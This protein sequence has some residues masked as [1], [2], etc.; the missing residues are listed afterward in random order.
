MKVGEK[1]SRY[2]FFLKS[3]ID[4]DEANQISI[5]SGCDFMV[6]MT[7][8]YLSTGYEVRSD[9]ATRTFHQL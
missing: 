5:E 7:D 4:V 8:K 2:A 3:L 1:A 6:I 9:G